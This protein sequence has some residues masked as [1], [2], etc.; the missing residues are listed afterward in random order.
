MKLPKLKKYD[1]I[2][3]HW[4]DI[5]SESSWQTDMKLYGV[6]CPSVRTLGRFHSVNSANELIFMHSLAE[7]GDGDYTV[8]PVEV[9][10]KVKKVNI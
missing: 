9:I 7:D 2:E 5:C 6:R 4:K 1:V 8:I 10:D 3:V